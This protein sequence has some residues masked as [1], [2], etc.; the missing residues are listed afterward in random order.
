MVVECRG[1]DVVD[2][3]DSETSQ[4]K[5]WL[6]II[7]GE[8]CELRF[9]WNQDHSYVVLTISLL[10]AMAAHSLILLDFT[11]IEREELRF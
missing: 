5:V 6:W 4:F 1:L 11:T 8:R 2:S 3:V 10:I 9:S 7:S